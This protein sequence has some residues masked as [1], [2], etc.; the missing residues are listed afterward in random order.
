MIWQICTMLLLSLCGCKYD[1][2]LEEQI[3]EKNIKIENLEVE[4]SIK[5][6]L[7]DL[8]DESLTTLTDGN[9]LVSETNHLIE[10]LTLWREENSENLTT[11]ENEYLLELTTELDTLI[12]NC[13]KVNPYIDFVESKYASFK[14]EVDEISMNSVQDTISI[15]VELMAKMELNWSIGT[16]TFGEEHMI[17]I[18]VFNV[19]D[20]SVQLYSEI[21]NVIF[22]S[23]SFFVHLDE[24]ETLSRTLLF[25]RNSFHSGLEDDIES[26]VGLYK[27]KI[28]LIGSEESWVYTDIIIEVSN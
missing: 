15:T 9:C 26:P 2:T 3:T 14:V 21:H 6:K 5:N 8:I 25:A 18:V 28:G 12:R 22:T 4:L 19:E 20:E 27:I 23:D 11:Y 16:S 24:S 7:L 10:M 13:N 1:S 17:S